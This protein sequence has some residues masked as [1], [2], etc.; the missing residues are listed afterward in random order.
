L[1]GGSKW[2]NEYTDMPIDVASFHEL[3]CVA[4]RMSRY[5][6]SR[7]Q[8]EVAFPLTPALSP[9][10][11]GNQSQ[12]LDDSWHASLAEALTRCLPLPKGEG[13]G[14][15]E[16][17]TRRSRRLDLTQSLFHLASYIPAIL[18]ATRHPHVTM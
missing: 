11:R 16:Q 3:S 18:G 7:R 10:E 12:S 15:G 14:E 13:W 6:G 5:I 2:A 9:G 1:A 4:A 8:P 17:H